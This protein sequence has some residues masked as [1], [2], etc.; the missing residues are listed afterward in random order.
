MVNQSKINNPRF[1]KLWKDSGA[2]GT[3]KQKRARLENGLEGSFDDL[4]ANIGKKV[5]VYHAWYGQFHSEKSTLKSVD[6]YQNLEIEGLS[7]PF[8]GYGSAILSVKD[9]EGKV[10]YSNP[11]IQDNYDVRDPEEREV[12]VSICF[13]KDIANKF[14]DERIKYQRRRDD[15]KA[16]SDAEAKTKTKDYLEKGRGL[17]KKEVLDDWETYVKTNTQDGYSAG[18]VDASIRVMT[19]LSK[20][21]TP[22]QADKVTYDLGITGFM[23]GCM[24]KAVSHFHPRG[25]EFRKYWNSRFMSEEEVNKTKGVVNP[26]IL[27]FS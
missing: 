11:H 14:K 26:A 25:E 13:G 10:L 3:I 17:I 8:I 19:A 4:R 5:T 2:I 12:L 20:G 6:D 15:A 24:A 1:W 22:E 9:D 27:T 16:K 7:I 18:V 23:A 21:K